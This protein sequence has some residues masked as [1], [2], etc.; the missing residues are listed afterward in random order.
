[1]KFDRYLKDEDFTYLS[2]FVTICEAAMLSEM[3]N[4]TFEEIRLAAKKLGLRVNRSDKIFDYLKDAGMWVNDFFRSAVLYASTDLKNRTLRKE[5]AREMKDSFKKLNKKEMAAFI[6]T[7]DK[8]TIG[9]TA[10]IRHVLQGLFG[11]EVTGYYQLHQQH[12]QN[13]INMRHELKLLKKHM[14]ERGA[15]SDDMKIVSHFGNLIDNLE[16]EGID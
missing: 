10:H 8:S 5:F 2:E 14:D 4:K 11:I 3:S 15:G 1:M 16:E 7:L 13:I 12:K 6:L 9:I